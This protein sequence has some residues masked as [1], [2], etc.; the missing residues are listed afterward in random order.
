MVCIDSMPEVFFVHPIAVKN[1]VK[2][3]EMMIRRPRWKVEPIPRLSV[4]Q[5]KAKHPV[6]WRYTL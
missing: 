2:V 1:W 3:A 6:R 4:F 5:E